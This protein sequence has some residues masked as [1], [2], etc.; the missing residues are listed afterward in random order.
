MRR[1]KV[2]G[3]PT[4]ES[5]ICSLTSVASHRR[6]TTTNGTARRWTDSPLQMPVSELANDLQEIANSGF[7]V[8]VIDDSGA[9]LWTCGDEQ[10]HDSGNRVNVALEEELYSSASG[11]DVSPPSPHTRQTGAVLVKP[12]RGWTC[13]RAPVGDAAGRPLGT[14]CFSTTPQQANALAASTVRVMASLIEAR[15]R[16]LRP[17]SDSSDA[18]VDHVSLRCL[19]RADLTVD[20]ISVQVSPRQAEILALLTLRPCGYSAGEL[21]LALYGDRQVSNS[22]LKAEISR[23]RRMIGGGIAAQRYVLTSQV[24]CDAAE[25]LRHL[26]CGQTIAAIDKY[27]GPLLPDSEA[28]GIVDWRDRIQVAVREAALQCNDPDAAITLG[29]RIDSD[30]ELYEHALNKLPPKDRRA[31]LVAG[32]LHVARRD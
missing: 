31:P 10:M 30:P 14:L 23:L 6:I 20:G 13:Y 21:R 15:V 8:S 22:T 7:V 29:E 18:A 2:R 1:V 26:S 27:R 11:L 12:L 5:S 19:G 16:E 24:W 25:V 32:R 3:H 17:Q 9:V 4:A 28:P